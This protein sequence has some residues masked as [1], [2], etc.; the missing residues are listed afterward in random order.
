M[1]NFLFKKISNSI[2]NTDIFPQKLKNLRKRWETAVTLIFAIALLLA[3]TVFVGYQA[4][5]FSGFPKG[6]DSFGHA[7]LIKIIRD[8][9]PQVFWNSYWY[10]GE[11]IFPRAY[12]PLYH[13]LSAFLAK[14]LQFK[15]ESLMVGMAMVN[16]G[17][18]VIFVFAIIYLSTKRALPSLIGAL[19]Y[20]SSSTLWSYLLLDGLY[21]RVFA[22]MTLILAIFALLLFFQRAEKNEGGWS[23]YLVIL[24]FTLVL[25]SHFLAAVLVVLTF[26]VLLLILFPRNDDRMVLTIKIW[27]P[28]LGLS[29]FFYLP[30]LF[31]GSGKQNLIGAFEGGNYIPLSFLQLFKQTYPGLPFLSLPLFLFLGLVIFFTRHSLSKSDQRIE[32]IFWACGLLTFLSLLYVLG[33]GGVYFSGVYPSQFLLTAALYLAIFIGLGLSLLLNFKILKTGFLLIITIG[34]LALS[35]AQV[36]Q[37]KKIVLDQSRAWPSLFFKETDQGRSFRFAHRYDVLGGAFN[38]YTSSLQTGGY[39]GQGILSSNFFWLEDA[40]FGQN[41]NSQ[42]TAFLLDWYGV[43]NFYIDKLTKDGKE[44]PLGPKLVGDPQDF[45]SV[46]NYEWIYKN[47]SEILAARQTP[48]V[49][50][51]TDEEQYR[52]ILKSL[53]QE[54]AGSREV[55]PLWVSKRE[56]LNKSQVPVVDSWLQMEVF[57]EKVAS[58]DAVRQDGSQT[59]KFVNN[60]RREVVIGDKFKGVLLKETYFPNWHAILKTTANNREKTTDLRIFQAGPGMMY[61]LLPVDYTIPAKVVFEYRLS[62]IEKIGFLISFVTLILII[63]SLLRVDWKRRFLEKLG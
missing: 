54:N 27:L 29:S 1:Y 41:D 20:L 53:A 36:P 24:S 15:I 38:F 25:L 60:Q 30:L 6:Y 59:A 62:L 43:K 58:S 57:L 44:F 49:F 11:I 14:L 16:I 13:F 35:I 42:E 3:L 37:L 7:S 33:I 39:W 5:A 55:I 21:P 56:R 4:T 18:S 19:F 34:F 47:A 50:V 12:P 51:K 46:S 2:K 63:L 22:Q 26:F 48:A 32:K 31:L 52:R 10:A 23:Y 9:F 45:V 8:N 28:V 40:V 61:V 17:L